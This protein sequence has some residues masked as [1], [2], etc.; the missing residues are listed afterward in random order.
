MDEKILKFYK[1]T[2]VFTDCGKYKKELVNLWKKKCKKSLKQLTL[3]IQNSTLHR[4]IL[5][6]HLN[7][8]NMSVYGDLSYIDFTTPMSEDDIF[9]TASAMVN[10]I[11]RRDEKG[12]YIGRPPQKRLNLTCHYISV[13][14]A[15][16]LKANNIPCRCRAGWG[17]Y[18]EQGEYWDHWVNEYW[19]E[20][21]Q[22]WVMFD[23][24]D[25]Y[26]RDFMKHEEYENNK[27]AYHYL[28]FG[29]E[30]FCS[31]AQAWLN[32][33]TNKDFVKTLVN[34]SS[35]ATAN[36]ILNYLFFDLFAVMNYE[37][38][39][40]FVPFAFDKPIEKLTKKELKELDELATLM[41]DV[42]KNFDRLKEI[43]D[44]TPKYRMLGSPLVDKINFKSLIKA[45]SYKL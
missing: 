38:N 11:F 30:Y 27:F 26:D 43:Y 29:S 45:K 7:G 3:Y 20:K 44:N 40:K 28:D 34:G 18:F 31:A 1:Q 32:Y 24:D 25:L 42:D 9:L 12:F 35:P 17:N 37:V 13:L 41:L 33:R 5:Q 15:A 39:Y 16:I 36:N 10:E 4:C 2:S 23:T 6:M 14:T 21:E 22:R 8:L 19:N